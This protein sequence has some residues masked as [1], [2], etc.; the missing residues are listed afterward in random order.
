MTEKVPIPTQEK[1]KWETK[2]E[3]EDERKSRGYL[4]YYN[5]ERGRKERSRHQNS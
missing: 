3:E 4:Q 5:G 1:I 2:G